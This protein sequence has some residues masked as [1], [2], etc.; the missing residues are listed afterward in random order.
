MAEGKELKPKSFRIDDETAE[1][2]K[3]I[4]N[5]IGG[6]Q[7]EAL[8]KLIEV[9]EFQ[10]GKAVLVERKTDIEQ[11]E[12]YVTAITRMF[13]GILEDNQNITDT[14]RTEFEAFIRSKD[15][16]IQEL[17][18]RITTAEQL[19][20][21]AVVKLKAYAEENNRLD[22]ENEGLR[23]EYRQK[24]D[25][26]QAMLE[27]KEKLNHALTDSC[28]DIKEKLDSMK[29]EIQNTEE[30]RK[31][32]DKYIKEY[33]I[34]IREKK[35]LEHAL[36]QERTDHEEVVKRFKE[37]LQFEKEKVTLDLEKLHHEQLQ[38]VAQERQ[39]EIDK[40]QQKYFSL[41]EQMRM[42]DSDL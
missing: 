13:M 29:D 14:V 26:M 27:D 3:D 28:N 11:F 35:D 12:K 31:E 16:T 40:Y 17:Q 37:Q 10:S 21:D 30:I 38:K 18:S 41:M 1:K 5:R 19:K 32:R 33:D 9:F 8:A 2:F 6:N 36:I 23:L 42:Q 4:S 25:D 24:M 7:Q 34:M 39:E 22:K 20:E 15:M